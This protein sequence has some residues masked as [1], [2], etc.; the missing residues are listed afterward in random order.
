M[1]SRP[2]AVWDDA[3]DAT[4]SLDNLP[5]QGIILSGLIVSFEPRKMYADY[6]LL[7]YSRGSMET[8]YWGGSGEWARWIGS[9][10]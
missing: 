3:A 10:F 8:V 4:L 2:M 7:R 1:W 5:K 9:K 6:M